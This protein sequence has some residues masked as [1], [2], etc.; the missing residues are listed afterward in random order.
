MH[1]YVERLNGTVMTEELFGDRIVRFLYS[2]A[3][4][5]AP[6]LFRLAT[7]ARMSSLLGLYHF[8]LR[9]APKLRGNARFLSRCGLDLAE[10]LAPRAYFTTPRRIFERQIRYWQCRPM[11]E[12]EGG[13]VS[14]A[15]ARVVLGAL[16][17][18]S[19]LFLKD[20]FFD[21]EELLG[22]DRRHWLELFAQGDYA[23][24]R[25]T[26][27]KYHYNHTPVSGRVVEHYSLDGMYHSC[28]PGAVVEIVTPYSK[29]KRVVTIIDTNVAGG[30]AVG[31]VAMVEVVALMIGDIVQCYSDKGYDHP[32][33]IRP[34]MFLSKGQ[35]KSLYRPG[36]STDILL[37]EKNRVRFSEDLQEKGRRTDVHSRFSLGF[38][39]P[40]VEIEV[41]VRSLIAMARK[42]DCL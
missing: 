41:Q 25:L 6:F 14:P 32:L 22:A 12:M 8:D 29:N 20:K 28:N 4:E 38:G 35:P 39:S 19:P 11:S 26:P 37:F 9:L 16:A 1:Q 33:R 17:P 36:S 30:T 40:L 21:Y 31:H 13:V 7:S 10:C 5:N 2:R 42:Q 34:G 27:D 15:D 18:D 3:R 23:V 24:F